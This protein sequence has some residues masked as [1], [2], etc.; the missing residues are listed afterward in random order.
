M[1]DRYLSSYVAQLLDVG[2]PVLIGDAVLQLQILALLQVIQQQLALQGDVVGAIGIGV[3][4]PLWVL[5]PGVEAHAIQISHGAVDIVLACGGIGVPHLQH[6]SDQGHHCVDGV[7]IVILQQLWQ[8]V[9]AISEHDALLLQQG[10]QLVGRIQV[11]VPAGKP[12]ILD[13]WHDALAG[14]ERGALGVK[15]C[16][17]LLEHDIPCRHKAWQS[18][19]EGQIAVHLKVQDEVACLHIVVQKVEA[20]QEVLSALVILDGLPH[21]GVHEA[22]QGIDLRC[23]WGRHVKQEARLGAHLGKGGEL[24]CQLVWVQHA[25]HFLCWIVLQHQAIQLIDQHLLEL[26]VHGLLCDSG[27]L[28]LKAEIQV[29]QHHHGL[30]VDHQVH[31]LVDDLAQIALLQILDC[32]HHRPGLPCC[33]SL[34]LPVVQLL[35]V[36][37]L[38]DGIQRSLLQDLA[39][40]V[41]HCD[42]DQVS[43]APIDADDRGLGVLLQVGIH[44]LVELRWGIGGLIVQCDR[45]VEKELVAGKAPILD[46]LVRHLLGDHVWQ[47]GPGLIR[48]VVGQAV[49][50]IV[51]QLLVQGVG[52]WCLLI[53]QLLVQHLLAQPVGHALH[54]GLRSVEQ[55]GLAIQLD[56]C[57]GQVLWRKQAGPIQCVQIRLAVV[58]LGKVLVID[59]E[60]VQLAGLH[61]IHDL[62]L[63]DALEADVVQQGIQLGIVLAQVLILRG[64][65]QA[66][67]IDRGCL[68]IL[69]QKIPCE[70]DP[71]AQGLPVSL[72]IA[73]LLGIGCLKL[74]WLLLRI[75]QVVDLLCDLQRLDEIVGQQDGGCVGLKVGCHGLQLGAA[76]WDHLGGIREVVI[77]HLIK[78]LGGLLCG[79]EAQGLIPALLLW[80]DAQIVQAVLHKQDGAIVLLL[81]H[82]PARGQCRHLKVQLE[83]LHGVGLLGGIIAGLVVEAQRRLHLQ[84]DAGQPGRELGVHLVGLIHGKPVQQV[85]QAQQAVQ[86]RLQDLLLLLLLQGCRQWLIQ[87][88]VCVGQDL[89]GLLLEGLAQ[90]L[91]CGR[92]DLLQVDIL[93]LQASLH[94]LL[95]RLGDLACQLGDS[96]LV[97]G[98]PQCIPVVAQ[99]A[100]DGLQ[101]LV[102]D[103]DVCQVDAVQLVKQGLGGLQH[104]LV[105]QQCLVLAEGLDHF[106]VALKL[107]QDER[108]GVP[109]GQ[110]LLKQGDEAVWQGGDDVGCLIIL[111]DGQIQHLV[112][113]LDLLGSCLPRDSSQQLIVQVDLGL[114]QQLVIKREGKHLLDGGAH[115]DADGLL[116]VLK[117]LPQAGHGGDQ[118]CE[119]VTILLKLGEVVLHDSVWDGCADILGAEHVL[120]VLIK[121]GEVGCKL[122]EAA[123]QGVLVLGCGHGA[124][125]LQH[126]AIKQL[127]L[128]QALVDL[129]VALIDGIGQVVCPADEVVV[130]GISICGLLL[131]QGVPGLLCLLLAIGVDGGAQVLPIQLHQLQALVGIGLVDPI[132]DGLQL[133]VVIISGLVLL[134]E[135]LLLDVLQGLA[136]WDQLKPQCLA[137]LIQVGKALELC[138][139]DVLCEDLLNSFLY[140]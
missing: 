75:V 45:H 16:L 97:Q 86:L 109:I 94:L 96:P 32:A 6:A 33:H 127:G 38:L 2:Q 135:A 90:L 114:C 101:L 82:V 39:G 72:L 1:V 98:I 134:D 44:P 108:Q 91:A 137:H 117:V 113:A 139:A 69:G 26:L 49:I 34:L 67:Q 124:Q 61:G 52:D 116:H 46:D 118:S 55:L 27:P 125:L 25:S 17:V 35:L 130:D 70:V 65:P 36:I 132:D 31:D 123:Q 79:L 64:W 60:Q 128:E 15:L 57:L 24:V 42:I 112:Q 21:E 121:A 105:A 133:L 63:G 7:R 66:R 29:G 119:D 22:G 122:I 93:V 111:L 115:E 136:L 129:G 11:S 140:H 76:L 126:L 103:E 78:A 37:K 23:I 62:L 18:P 95:G 120:P 83:L 14:D 48:Q 100:A 104:I 12:V 3:H 138:H 43:L 73:G 47:Q 20:L 85:V 19:L 92:D 99:G 5:K 8:D 102:A 13:H 110:D 4:R 81:I 40:G 88:G 50:H 71:L 9:G 87:G 58:A 54:P 89:A 74:L 68:G 107:L 80:H 131:D 51:V 84:L 56:A 53:L 41:D 77:V 59:L 106:L 30:V 28:A 10:D